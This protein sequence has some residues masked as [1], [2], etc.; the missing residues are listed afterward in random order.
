MRV[1]RLCGKGL[2]DFVYPVACECCNQSCNAWCR[3][4]RVCNVPLY[5]EITTLAS[6]APSN[7]LLGVIIITLT[8]RVRD[9]AIC[10]YIEH[11]ER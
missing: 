11:R 9:S 4:M 5:T 1:M 3:A 10:D 8:C 2:L 6:I 7:V